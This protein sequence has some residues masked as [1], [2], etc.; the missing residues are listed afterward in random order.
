MDVRI[1]GPLEV[2][3]GGRDVTPRR[4]KHRAALAFM[5]LHANERLATDRIID[6][7]WGDEPPATADKALQGH[8]ST[9]RK[10]LGPGRIQTQGGA[11]R[12]VLQPGELDADRFSEAI[13]AARSIRDPGQRARRLA[14]AIGLWRGDPVA[15][16][17]AERFA[18]PE[19][20]R[21][22]ALRLAAVE[23]QAEAELEAGHHAALLPE[24]EAL[25]QRHPLSE[26]LRALLMLA[27]YRAGRQAD[28]LRA[29]HDGR[30]L[31]AEDLGLDPSPELQVLERRILAQDPSLDAPVALPAT[32]RLRQERKL[33]TVLVAEAVPEH[34]T[35]PEDLERIAG[36]A[37]A[38][39]RSVVERLG[40]TAEPLFA[41]ALLGI[42][43]APR[44]HEDDAVRA[45]R[46]ALD[47]QSAGGGSDLMIRGGIEAGEAL[48]TIDDDRVEVT[49][50]VLAAAARL[51]AAA[52]PGSI[53]VG[54]AA[55]RLTDATVEY[56]ARGP[57]AWSPQA[58]REPLSKT[59]DLEAPLV[60]R[61]DELALLERSYLRAR[62]ESS[63]QLATVTA[64]PGGGKSRLVRELRTALEASAAPPTWRQGRCLPYGDGVTFWALGE[65]I[66]A[67]AGILETDD[68][69]TSAAKLSAAV[70]AVEPDAARRVWFERG[71]SALA[72]VEG[73]AATGSHEQSFAVWAQFLEAAAGLG[74]LVIVFEDIH[75]ADE[76]LLEF[77]EHLVIRTSGVPLLVLCT[78]R[79]E[80]FDARPSWG[81]GVRNGTTIALAPLAPADTERLLQWLLRREPETSLIKR[82][83]GN[84][85]F[86][87]ELARMSDR[88][89]AEGSA[90][91]PASL[92][93][94]IAARLDALDPDVKSVAADASVVG[95]VFWSGAVAAMGGLTDDEVET[96]L[97][98]LVANDVARRRRSSSVAGQGEYGFLHG[99][100]R[101]VAYG[102][103]PRRDRIAKHRA[104]G[105]WIEQLAGDRVTGHAELIAHHYAQALQLAAALRDEEDVQTLMPRARTFLAMAGDGALALDATQA[106]SFYRRALDLTDEDSPGHGRLLG[107]LGQVADLTGRAAEAEQLCRQAIVELQAHDDLLGAGEAMVTLAGALWRLGRPEGQRRRIAAEAIRTLEQL[108]P[109]P[110]LVTA[111]SRMATHELHAGRAKACGEW[112]HKAFVLADRLGTVALKVQPLHHLGIA[113]FESGDEAGIDDIRE[114]VRIGLEAGL[115]AE[116]A[117]AHSNLAATLWVTDGPVVA[118]A[119]KAAAAAF[120]SS[121]GLVA[122][123]KTIRAESL[124]HQ[125]DAGAWDDALESAA[126]L[127][128]DG[129]SGSDRVAMMARTVKGRILVE[130]GRTREASDLEREFLARARELRDPQDLGPA[131]AAAAALRYG[132]GDLGAAAG[133]IDELERVTRGRDPSQRVHELPLAARVCRASGTIEVAEALIPLRGAPTYIRA[134]LCLSSAR[135]SIAEA[136]G[137]FE[138][139]LEL[140]GAAAAGWG[141][142]GCPAEEAHAL[143]GH[144]RCL[145]AIG[146]SRDAGRSAR[147]A[148]RI[149]RRLRAP[150][151]EAEAQALLS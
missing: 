133:M 125:F 38:R 65:V 111:Y 15:D 34:E 121:R 23:D 19:T 45:V 123:E 103:I 12:L 70:A 78:A 22:E 13:T 36:P 102:Q 74:P 98:R 104:A 26:R 137:D 28:A 91:I 90:G 124:W 105:E 80:L 138:T 49:G 93:A 9:L 94:V 29:Y 99:L 2:R 109:G 146:R 24:L 51:Q 120:A 136:R 10:L 81:G 46:A 43:G 113:R 53:L 148:L 62:D 4:A 42:F 52:R 1:L 14:E 37:V 73:A 67:H 40:G 41:N 6:A 86:A 17:G 129:E 69:L 8:I 82:A 58:L 72:G 89:D 7:L 5:V 139:A 141:T 25:A 150:K 79:L 57:N 32:N 50:D 85:L 122:F 18:G 59:V 31:L 39:I 117:A 66:K 84:P 108:P 119:E 76:A 77:I 61:A 128:A 35:D 21:L 56:R 143:L 106:E 151:I 126:L 132:L 114:A 3:V 95:E 145:I 147:G 130:R 144:A 83:S 149:A 107:R 44:A 64:E 55:H 63:V 115:S 100:V 142:F 75:W 47:L 20:A 101:D 118:L 97:Q 88:A 54:S 127:L 135:G 116:T 33:V 92:Q 96:Q 68:A 140:H 11:Y 60:G 112:S 110:A 134:R 27:L 87:H 71:L 131:L 30:R 16:L 48:V